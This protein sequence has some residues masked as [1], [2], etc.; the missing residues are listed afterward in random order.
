MRVLSCKQP[1][2]NKKSTRIQRRYVF[3]GSKAKRFFFQNSIAR[4]LKI[5]Q[6]KYFQQKKKTKYK[7]SQINTYPLA[8]DANLTNLFDSLDENKEFLHHDFYGEQNINTKDNLQH[9]TYKLLRR[10]LIPTLSLFNNYLQ[11]QILADHIAKEFERTK[12]HRPLL[13]ALKRILYA[14][15]FKRGIGLRVAIHGRINSATKS[16]AFYI[17]RQAL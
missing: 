3:L 10:Q 11:P 16:R 12:K 5:F 15:P 6:A 8:K 14:L 9:L 17:T 4:N 2:R 13:F 7:L 1:F